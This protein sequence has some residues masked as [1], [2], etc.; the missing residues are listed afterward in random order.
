MCKKYNELKKMIRILILSFFASFLSAQQN[1]LIQ[2]PVNSNVKILY[3]G[4][5]KKGELDVKIFDREW[6]GLFE[7]DNIS[8]IRKVTLRLDKLEPDIQYD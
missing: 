4:D 7:H 5:Y 1:E 3:V 2:Y 8:Y 6:W